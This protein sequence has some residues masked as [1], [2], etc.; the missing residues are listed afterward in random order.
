MWLAWKFHS[1]IE[2]R[3]GESV[4]RL[5]ITQPNENA[6]NTSSVTD[7]NAQ[8]LWFQGLDSRKVVADFSGGTLSSNGGARKGSE[9]CGPRILAFQISP[10]SPLALP[11]E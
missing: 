4:S 7:C 3:S 2:P 6:F 9:R 1:G 11:P 5:E 8:P 10:S